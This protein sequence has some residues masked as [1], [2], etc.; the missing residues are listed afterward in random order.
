M[1]QYWDAKQSKPDANAAFSQA[2][3][4]ELATYHILEED[5]LLVC[6]DFFIFRE[7]K[8][9]VSCSQ[10]WTFSL[11]G[12]SMSLSKT[13]SMDVLRILNP[14]RIVQSCPNWMLVVNWRWLLWIFGTQWCLLTLA[15]NGA[16]CPTCPTLQ[17]PVYSVPSDF[18]YT[19]DAPAQRS[20][21]YTLC[22]TLHWTLTLHTEYASTLEAISY[23]LC[24]MPP[25]FTSVAQIRASTQECVPCIMSLDSV[26]YYIDVSAIYYVYAQCTGEGHRRVSYVPCPSPLPI[27]HS[28]LPTGL[29]RSR[30]S[31]SS[32]WKWSNLQC[33]LHQAPCR[34]GKSWIGRI[35]MFNI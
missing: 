27:P 31:P 18:Y 21:S 34:Q 15:Q 16:T 17:N 14:C 2:C 29:T 13:H 32:R 9:S 20:V 3:L 7:P 1:W 12:A 35:E 5:S 6:M 26:F 30:R 19:Q 33:S 24:P 23:V 22:L 8:H 25:E 10:W 4:L 11:W 28:G